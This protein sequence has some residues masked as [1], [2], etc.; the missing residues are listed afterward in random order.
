MTQTQLV[1]QPQVSKFTLLRG[2]DV[3]VNQLVDD[4]K[5][6]VAEIIVNDTFHHRFAATSRVSKHLD[7][8]TPQELQM[9]LTGG[10][11]FFIGDTLQDCRDGSYNGFVHTDDTV[12]KFMDVLGYQHKD[13]MRFQHSRKRSEGDTPTSNIVLQKTWSK[14]EIIVPGYAQGTDF[15]SEL[16]FMW[17][18]FVK[19]INSTFDLVRMICENGMVGMTSFLNTKVPLVNRFE[20]H[21]DIASRQIQN[22]VNSVMVERIQTM[23]IDRAS[24]ADCL[25]VQQH[26]MDRLYSPIE[27]S[28][29][30]NK[31][32][33]CMLAAVSP[34][35]HLNEV[36]HEGVFADKNLASQLPAHLSCFDVFNIATEV[37]THTSP[38]G[39]SSDAALDKFSNKLL[40]DREDNYVASASRTTASRLSPF[41]GAEQAFFGVLH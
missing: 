7:V 21:L 17:N 1:T 31:R 26:V 33:A 10:T 20:E 19:T 30:E 8:M 38:C 22:K 2:A 28:A 9:R 12:G 41:S 6:N 18:P 34:K 3:R 25:L 37:R 36:Y 5:K 13:S 23:A 39:K 32:L 11:Y 29:E 35:T 15:S 4:K 27:R 24:V 40:F 16:S 14:S